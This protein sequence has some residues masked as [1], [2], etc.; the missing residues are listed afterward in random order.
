MRV[1]RKK[2]RL[3]VVENRQHESRAACPIAGSEYDGMILSEE[4]RKSE[5]QQDQP[6]DKDSTAERREA[7]GV[8]WIAPCGDRDGDAAE[9]GK[10]GE[11]RYH[12]EFP[13]KCY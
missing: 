3:K 2:G 6:G 5:R 11:H 9:E 4:N 13:S 1:R 7:M 12:H 10:A 8:R